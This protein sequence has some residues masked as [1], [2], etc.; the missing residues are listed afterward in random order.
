[1]P[2]LPLR[3][4]AVLAGLALV[5]IAWSGQAG[6]HFSPSGLTLAVIPVAAIGVF[7]DLTR[8]SQGWTD[9]AYYLALWLATLQVL[10]I[11]SFLAASVGGPLLDDQF[12]RI[13]AALGFSWRAWHDFVASAP[14]LNGILALAYYSGLLQVLASLIYFART[15][16]TVGNQELWWTALAGLLMTVTISALLPAIGAFVH[17]Q[18]D[19]ARA[20]H[21]ATLLALRDGSITHFSETKGI[22]TLPS[23]HTTQAILL[24]YVHRG[25]RRV[26]P[27]AVLLN[28][29]M[30]LSTPTF[31]GHY[32]IDMIAG[33]AVAAVAILV[34][35]AGLGRQALRAVH[36]GARPAGAPC[37]LA[38]VAA[39]SEALPGIEPVTEVL[40]PAAGTAP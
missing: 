26:L 31:G 9:G 12:E 17:F 8:R 30:L 13:D 35:R 18:S 1:M 5:G 27:S 20:D 33:A 39:D 6:L 22:V 38:P 32:L 16:Q 40:P 34:V 36:A 23:Y 28:L 24:M 7:C 4:C 11:L 3:A 25:Q 37:V 2:Q 19:L 21:A 10:N 15:G 14:T 29:L